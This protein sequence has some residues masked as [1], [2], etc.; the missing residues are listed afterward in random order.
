[1]PARGEKCF[2]TSFPVKNKYIQK[3]IFEKNSAGFDYPPN[4]DL[5]M[6]F[7]FRLFASDS[8]NI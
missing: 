6:Y 5:H 4:N 7:G 8:K 2:F 3:N 1:M